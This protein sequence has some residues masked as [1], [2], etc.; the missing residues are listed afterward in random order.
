MSTV[1]S[2]FFTNTCASART[3]LRLLSVLLVILFLGQVFMAFTLTAAGEETSI[4]YFRENGGI[5]EEKIPDDIELVWE[6]DLDAGPIDSSPVVSDGRLIVRTAGVFDWDSF[7]FEKKPVLACYELGAGKLFW[8]E[9][10]EH[11]SGW[12][13]STP[14]IFDN[15][16]FVGSTAGILSA[17]DLETGDHLWQKEFENSS[18]NLGITSSPVTNRDINHKSLVVADGTGSLYSLRAEDGSEIWN[19]TLDGQVYFT[20]PALSGTKLY[21]GTDAGTFY[22]VNY[23]TGAEN[24]NLSL[25]GKVRT[26]PF[27]D[28][29]GIYLTTIT[30]KDTFTPE[31]G[32]LYHLRD[33][34][35][36]GEIVWQREKE[37]S[38]SSVVCSD[39]AVFYTSGDFVFALAKD[40][41]SVVWE[42]KIEE[43]VQASLLYS[44]SSKSLLLGTNVEI[45]QVLALR[46]SNGERLWFEQAPSDAP[47]FASPIIEDGFLVVCTDAGVV[48]VYQG[49]DLD[50]HVDFVSLP[51]LLVAL[52]C[53]AVLYRRRE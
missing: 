1:E 30:Y 34:G 21:I 53:G 45:G 8:K 49:L 3:G 5:T 18:M 28:G 10:L 25:D 17:Y 37:P 4:S 19:L 9:E 6:E 15:K 29:E 11:G 16:V 12:E 43:S 39:D 44:S 31:T 2:R 33:V 14:L 38:S 35:N 36:N 47:I 32:Y 22:C 46:G 40:N 50:L 20:S 41:S 27:L 23:Q 42:H 7:S 52:G 24:W 26:T 13:L 48:H 51:L